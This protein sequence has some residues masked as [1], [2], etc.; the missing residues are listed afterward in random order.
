MEFPE[1]TILQLSVTSFHWPLNGSE[2]GG[3]LILIKTSLPLCFY[4]CTVH[5]VVVMLTGWHL[6]EEGKEACIKHG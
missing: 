1:Y 2:V 5:Q 4:L 6:N 3:D